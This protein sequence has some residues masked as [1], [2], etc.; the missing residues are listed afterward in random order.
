MIIKN[1][2]STRYNSESNPG[3]KNKGDIFSPKSPPLIKNLLS[4]GLQDKVDVILLN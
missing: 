2:S 3:S 4:Y 1:E